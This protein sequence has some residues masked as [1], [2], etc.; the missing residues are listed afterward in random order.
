LKLL[1][2]PAAGEEKDEGEQPLLPAAAA[3]SN[4]RQ[5]MAGENLNWGIIV[6]HF[7]H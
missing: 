7:W 3:E 4:E 1:G 2:H 5:K 6:Y